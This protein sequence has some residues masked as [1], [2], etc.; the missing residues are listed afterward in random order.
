MEPFAEKEQSFPDG[1][2][3]NPVMVL[4]SFFRNPKM[5][6]N[7]TDGDRRWNEFLAA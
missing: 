7:N 4:G 2:S 6:E 1:C 5:P 3:G